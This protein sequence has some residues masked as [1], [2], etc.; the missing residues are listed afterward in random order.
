MQARRLFSDAENVEPLRFHDMRGTFVTWARRQGRG[1]G[2]ITDRTGHLTPAMVER[3]NRA[4]RMLA[5]LRYDPF[6]D[7]SRAIPELFEVRLELLEELA[8]YVRETSLCGLGMTAPN[9]LVSTLRYFREEY[10]IHIEQKRCPTGVCP[11]KPQNVLM[12]SVL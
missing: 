10:M 6:P 7:I 4:A 5:D 12:E 2:W 8:P 3:Y 9:P 1:D 11:M